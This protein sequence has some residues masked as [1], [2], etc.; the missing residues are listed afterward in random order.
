MWWGHSRLV[1]G[2]RHRPNPS[3]A[4]RRRVSIALAAIAVP[5]LAV[6]LWLGQQW[7]VE[8]HELMG[9]GHQT[10]TPGSGFSCW[11]W[12]ASASWSRSS[13][14]WWWL[15][16]TLAGRLAPVVPRHLARPLAVGL[17]AALVVGLNNGLVWRVLV[18]AANSFSSLTNS[19]T[20]PGDS[21]PAASERPAARAH[22]HPGTRWAAKAGTSWPGDRA[23]R[24]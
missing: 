11:G 7:Q 14:L 23:R 19:A 1:R 10:R 18:E 24:S 9:S 5:L 2:D 22:R 12:S 17:V 3:A 8:L 20:K 21:R 16:R 13:R 6:T 15:V 4:T